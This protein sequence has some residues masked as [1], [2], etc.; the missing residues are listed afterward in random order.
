MKYKLTYTI[1][2][3]FDD[4]DERFIRLLAFGD[5]Q[6]E[7]VDIG[8][9]IRGEFVDM[10][11]RL[12]NGQEIKIERDLNEQLA[13]RQPEKLGFRTPDTVTGLIVKIHEPIPD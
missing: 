10:I 6:V 9:A 3:T 11:K 8:P 1:E 4:E 13:G 7:S 12:E 5:G 2:H